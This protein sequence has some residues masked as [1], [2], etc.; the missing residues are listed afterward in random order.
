MDQAVAS[1]DGKLHDKLAIVKFIYEKYYITLNASQAATKAAEGAGRI[2]KNGLGCIQKLY[3]S[4][5]I[6][7]AASTAMDNAINGCAV[8]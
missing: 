5:Y 6:T 3:D 8:Q 2:R 7:Q 4:Y 1:S